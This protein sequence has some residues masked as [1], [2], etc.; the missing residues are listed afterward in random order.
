MEL[1]Y[2]YFCKSIVCKVRT[3]WYEAVWGNCEENHNQHSHNLSRCKV[4]QSHVLDAAVFMGKLPTE[5]HTN[6]LV[7]RVPSEAGHRI[8]KHEPED[9]SEHISP[10]LGEAARS[11]RKTTESEIWS[12]L[13]LPGSLHLGHWSSPFTF[14]DSETCPVSHLQARCGTFSTRCLT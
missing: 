7:Q 2:A 8:I 12:L 1:I 3:A 4:G 14:L 11:S 10:T 6:T 5:L 9:W 13:V